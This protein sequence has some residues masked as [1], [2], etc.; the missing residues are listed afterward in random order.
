MGVGDGNEN[1]GLQRSKSEATSV[2]ALSRVSDEVDRGEVRGV[3]GA[4]DGTNEIG[5]AQGYERGE[6]DRHRES[7]DLYDASPIVPKVGERE[8]WK[9]HHPS[10]AVTTVARGVEE[11]GVEERRGDRVQMSATSYPGME[12]NPYMGGDE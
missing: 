3:G 5:Y 7:E 1:E 11:G 8:I 2:S 10:A 9:H 6:R 4:V 12:W